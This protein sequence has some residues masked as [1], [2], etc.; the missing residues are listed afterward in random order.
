MY[1]EGDEKLCLEGQEGFGV[2]VEDG[3]S[4]GGAEKSSVSV[5]EGLV[6]GKGEGLGVEVR[7]KYKDQTTQPQCNLYKDYLFAMPF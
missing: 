4:V 7:E 3:L 1:V 5:V 2:D 6:V